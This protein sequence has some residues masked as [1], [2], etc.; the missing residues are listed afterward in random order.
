M[1]E[2]QKKARRTRK[3]S[4]TRETNNIK[5]FIAEENRDEVSARIK[6]LTVKY[7]DFEKAHDAYHDAL[8]E[9]DEIDESEAYLEDVQSKYIQT[10]TSAKK[11]LLDTE[12]KPEVKPDIAPAQDLSS[13]FISLI[14]LPK[15]EIEPF[16]GNPMNYH[17]F[18]A[19][20]REHVDNTKLTP[21]I[22]L[23]R[24]VQYT[25][26]PAKKAILPCVMQGEGG[27]DEALVILKKRFGSTIQITECLIRGVKTGKSIKT[28]KDL[29][30]FSDDLNSC[31]ATL[32]SMGRL[33]E[34]DI[35]C[36]Y[37]VVASAYCNVK[38]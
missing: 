2:E 1:A 3:S 26:G 9:E 18:M 17:S 4:L 19:L 22:K 6:L 30:T 21:S 33:Q 10:L 29:Q 37:A 25:T 32:S 7:S 14:N 13:D 16:D 28:P 8:T 5:R 36:V 38:Y 31:Q 15:V 11:W 20:F 34:I 24:L 27:Y 23:S 12:A 35:G